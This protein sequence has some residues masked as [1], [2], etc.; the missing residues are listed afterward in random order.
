MIRKGLVMR[1]EGYKKI[2]EFFHK[3]EKRY[4]IFKLIYELATMLFV[5]GYALLIVYVFCSESKEAIVRVIFV[6][7]V[8]FLLCTVLRHVFNRKRPY[9]TLNIT[10]LI[11]KD[12]KGHSFPSRHVVSATIIMMAAS[13]VNIWIGLVLFVICVVVS[14]FRVLAGVHYISDVIGG[15]LFSVICG[16]LGFYLI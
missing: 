8:T 14:V 2:Y 5:I 13:Y 16:F 6:P 4:N 7:A 10:P 15:I 12:K 9:E 3:S 1:E 11:P